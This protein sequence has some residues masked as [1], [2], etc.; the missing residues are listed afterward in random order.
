MIYSLMWVIVLN[1]RNQILKVTYT[2]ICIKNPK[3]QIHR[4]RKH[5]QFPGAKRKEEWE[6][7]FSWV[8]RNVCRFTITAFLSFQNLLLKFLAILSLGPNRICHHCPVICMFSP[9][10]LEGQQ[11]PPDKKVMNLY[12]L[13][14]D[15][16]FHEKTLLKQQPVHSHL[17][18]L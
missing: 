14:S 1:E 9:P 17:P 2:S 8:C 10:E 18:M 16:V 3:Q 4:N 15:L 12:L 6:V 11:C 13:P 7:T 5:W